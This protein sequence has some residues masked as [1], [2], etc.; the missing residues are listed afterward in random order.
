MNDAMLPGDLDVPVV[1]ERIRATYIE[2]LWSFA[3]ST[4]DTPKNSDEQTQDD[5]INMTKKHV[6][7]GGS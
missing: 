6:Y 7:G 5:N 4:I 1:F 3:Y 2:S